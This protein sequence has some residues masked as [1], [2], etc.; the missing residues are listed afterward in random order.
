MKLSEAARSAGCHIETI[1]HYERIGLIPSP[2]RNFTHYRTYSESDV[3]RIA[4]I[5]RCRELGFSY[6]DIESLLQC[7]DD[8]TTDCEAMYA[9]AQERLAEFK[10]RLEDLGK[11]V[12]MLECSR[13]V[14]S[15]GKRR[16]DVLLTTL[17]H[18]RPSSSSRSAR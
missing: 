17:G 11:L 18:F 14:G 12:S 1:R 16:V 6:N 13:A 10:S 4:F 8:S 9:V 2:A 5:A 3:R 15:R 7:D